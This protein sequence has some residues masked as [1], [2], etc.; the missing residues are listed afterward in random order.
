LT[1]STNRLTDEIASLKASLEQQRRRLDILESTPGNGNGDMHSRRNLLKLA[2]AGL[3]GAAGAAA[4]RV[5]PASAATGGNFILGGIN[6]ADK[7][8][9]L[10]LTAETPSGGTVANTSALQVDSTNAL[11]LLS[12]T[13]R[14]IESIGQGTGAGVAGMSWNGP[15]GLFG[16]QGGPD[17][18]LG[19][20]TINF[21]SGGKTVSGTGRLAQMMNTSV[22]AA[23]PGTVPAAGFAEIVRGTDASMW[24]STT[25]TAW[26]RM[27][28][29]RVDKSDGSGGVF[30]P[31]RILDTRSASGPTGGAPLSGG[32]T[33]KFGPYTGTNGIPADAIGIVGNL[34]VV[35]YTGAGY[36]S[37]FPGGTAWPGTSSLNFGPPFASS[38]WAN[39]F[40]VGFGS[41]ADKGKF[42]LY[43]SANGIS[44]HAVVDVLGYLQ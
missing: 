34:T 3:V 33:Y 39:F 31:A 25:A 24:A 19:G 13:M 28:S 35:S 23:G 30:T 2:G 27:N 36:I 42:S 44:T 20:F 41:G 12:G 15:G 18:Q 32:T 40:V 1:E 6:Q 43:V 37:I 11:T 7:I 22:A 21:T 26:R 9:V 38:G 4:L 14:G 8:S 17:L 5:L 29:L 10:R 16:S